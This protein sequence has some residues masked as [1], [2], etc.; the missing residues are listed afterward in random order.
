MPTIT[1]YIA[2]ADVED[3]QTFTRYYS[4]LSTGGSISTTQGSRTYF[5]DVLH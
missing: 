1:G 5:Y 3:G 2:I 4:T